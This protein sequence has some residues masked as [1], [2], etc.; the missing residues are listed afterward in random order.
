MGSIEGSVFEFEVVTN[1][2]VSASARAIA[3]AIDRGD[4]GSNE[5]FRRTVGAHEFDIVRRA[6]FG[7]INLTFFRNLRDLAFLK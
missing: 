6:F 5:G 3:T 7:D 4:R 2:F 1:V